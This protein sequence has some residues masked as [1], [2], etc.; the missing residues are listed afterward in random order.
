MSSLESTRPAST[1]IVIARLA[2]QVVAA[3]PAVSA[4]QGGGRWLTRDGDRVI[5]GIV[6]AAS[7]DGRVEVGLHL[8]A[9]M[10]PRPMAQ[11]AADLR[12]D[13]MRAARQVGVAESVGE[14]DVSI[15]DLV[16]PEE[17]PGPTQAPVGGVDA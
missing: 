9:Y 13:L 16:A 12:S 5:P 14:I 8:N 4:T 11:Q 15:H 3:D 10:P 6:A 17:I 2:E 7:G 1:R